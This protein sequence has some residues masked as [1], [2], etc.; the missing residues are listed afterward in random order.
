V[1]AVASAKGGVGKST[2]ATYL[3]CALA[4]DDDVALFD[5]DIHGPN[6]PELL[7]VNGAVQSSEEGDPLP[8]RSAGWT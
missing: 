4:A 1:I 2:T 7:D 3:A 6:V 8:C 5:A